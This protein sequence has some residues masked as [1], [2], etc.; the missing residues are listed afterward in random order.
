MS[1]DAFLVMPQTICERFEA[2]DFLGTGKLTTENVM[3]ILGELPEK[4]SE[5]EITSLVEKGMSGKRKT[6]QMEKKKSINP[7][8]FVIHSRQRWVRKHKI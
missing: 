7:F 4:L 6:L 1:A 2:L 8:F 5:A 3:R